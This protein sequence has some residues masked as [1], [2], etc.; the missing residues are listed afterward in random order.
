MNHLG[1]GNFRLLKREVTSRAAVDIFQ[2]CGVS[3]LDTRSPNSRGRVFEESA[4]MNR[5]EVKPISDHQIRRVQ[6]GGLIRRIRP[7]RILLFTLVFGC[8]VCSLWAGKHRRKEDYGLGF[9]T[10]FDAPEAE[11][12]Q[13]VQAVVDDGIIQGSKEYNKDKSIENATEVASSGLFAEWKEPGKVFYKVRTQVLDPRGFYE[14]NDVGTLAVRYVVQSKAASKTVLKIDA[15]FVEDFRHTSHPSDGSVE[16]AEY[17]DIQDHLDALEEQKK[18]AVEGERSRQQEVARRALEE[19][20]QAQETEALALAQNSSLSLEDRVHELRRQAERLVKAPGAKLK[21]A[22]FQSASVLK[23]LDPGTEVVV[24][25]KTPYWFGIE[26]EDGQHGWIY[27][28]QL[29]SLP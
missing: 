24:V 14:S 9:T 3:E 17:K 2:C 13:A 22:P 4:C 11:V 29:E 19:K 26:T 6:A 16:S 23:S 10:E 21:S 25:V 5:L 8:S 1:A 12:L 7:T 18:Q 20:A 15:V 27:H 28:D